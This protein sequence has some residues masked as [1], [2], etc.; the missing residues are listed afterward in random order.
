M[1][2]TEFKLLVLPHSSRLY[3]LA[4]RLLGSREEAEDTVQEVY[5]KLWKMRDDL[6]QY[7]SIEA[8]CVR[9]TRNLCLDQLRRKKTSRQ[10]QEQEPPESGINFEDPSVEM[11]KSERSEIMNKLINLLPEP[12]RSLVYFRHIEGKEYSEIEELMSMKENAIRVSISRARKQLREML[13]KQYASWT[14]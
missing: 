1:K 12:Q 2:S 9:I 13:Q 11:L 10:I 7:N 14:N 3:R 6:P 4:F 8:L 5:L